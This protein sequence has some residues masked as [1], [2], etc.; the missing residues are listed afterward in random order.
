MADKLNNLLELI[1][2]DEW[3]KNISSI[4]AVCRWREEGEGGGGGGGGGGGQHRKLQILI[5]DFYVKLA[6][7]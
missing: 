5:H 1:L 2:H 4:I 3:E 6:T 7:E